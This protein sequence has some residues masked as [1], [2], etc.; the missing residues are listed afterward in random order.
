MKHWRAILAVSLTACAASTH[1]AQVD[2]VALVPAN[3]RAVGEKLAV[4]D[5]VLPGVLGHVRRNIMYEAPCGFVIRILHGCDDTEAYEAD[6]SS[7]TSKVAARTIHIMYFIIPKTPGPALY[8]T[9]IRAGDA[10]VWV[11]HKNWITPALACAQRATLTSTG[12]L[13]EPWLTLES[14]DDVLPLDEW[15]SVLEVL[16]SLGYSNLR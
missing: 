16:R 5:L 8:P 13:S 14:N 2:R 7:D 12:C 10:A 3:M 4:A 9:G 11:L 15:P 1:Q 6:I